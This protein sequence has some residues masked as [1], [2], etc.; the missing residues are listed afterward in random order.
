MSSHYLKEKS[1]KFGFRNQCI[2]L[3]HKI[4][5]AKVY[6][7]QRKF[8]KPRKGQSCK[9]PCEFFCFV[10]LAKESL[11]K[12]LTNTMIARVEEVKLEDE[13]SRTTMTHELRDI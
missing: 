9:L 11:R 3:L 1:V 10:P 2:L 6:K 12:N 7:R 8:L 5:Q 4:E 13:K